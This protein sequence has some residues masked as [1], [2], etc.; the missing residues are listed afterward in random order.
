MGHASGSPVLELLQRLAE[1]LADRTVDE[2]ELTARRKGGDQ[3]WNAVHDQARLAVAFSQV[4]VG[5]GEVEG[6]R[7]LIR[8]RLDWHVRSRA[9]LDKGRSRRRESSLVQAQP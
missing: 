4:V 9:S 6:V 3:S 8:C 1:V 7:R 2:F 5:Y